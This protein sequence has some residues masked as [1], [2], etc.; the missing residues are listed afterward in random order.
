[1][2][3]FLSCSK[4]GNL[5]MC[6]TSL[7]STHRATS[8]SWCASK[9]CRGGGHGQGAVGRVHGSCP[10]Q[11]QLHDERCQ[12]EGGAET[13]SSCLS[14]TPTPAKGGQLATA[15]VHS[16]PTRQLGL[17]PRPGLR[18]WRSWG[19]EVCRGGK[20]PPPSLLRQR[21]QLHTPHNFTTLGNQPTHLPCHP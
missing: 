9:S 3:V 6:G 13:L 4:R 5:M 2:C 18:R 11:P 20:H 16:Q 8:T 7:S 15:T 19:G 10:A 14:T 1:M 21:H 17:V 12:E